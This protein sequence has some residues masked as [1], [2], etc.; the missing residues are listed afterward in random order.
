MIYLIIILVVCIAMFTSSQNKKKGEAKKEVEADEEKELQNIT[1]GKIIIF[2]LGIMILAAVGGSKLRLFSQVG[3]V[4][5]IVL[6]I[7]LGYLLYIKL[8]SK[9]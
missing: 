7:F 2:L 4:A 3:D 5:F 1:N 8:F 6:I 9:R